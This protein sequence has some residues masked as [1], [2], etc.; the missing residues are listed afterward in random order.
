[1]ESSAEMLEQRVGC[2]GAVSNP[3][4]N[5]SASGGGTFLKARIV[6][7]VQG[8]ANEFRRLGIGR[9]RKETHE[10][11]SDD[12]ETFSTIIKVSSLS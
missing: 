5:V 11:E 10:A 4:E 12:T 2:F 1:M 6:L 9:V 3:N 8:A 7:T